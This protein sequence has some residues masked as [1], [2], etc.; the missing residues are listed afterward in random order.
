[1]GLDMY[2]Y[3]KSYVQNW[4]H[5]TPEQR[6][7]ITVKKN[8]NDHPTIKPERIAYVVEQVGYWRKFNALHKWFVENVQNGDDDCGNYPVPFD[9][10]EELLDLMNQLKANKGNQVFAES[11]LPTQSGFFFGSTSYD[12]YY[13]GD[14]EETIKI[15]EDCYKD[16]GAQYFYNSSW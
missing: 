9:K 2:L 4:D 5:F 3:K 7:E 11:S 14:V 16:E 6:T 15:L 1:M 10:I 13:W 12:E 8:G